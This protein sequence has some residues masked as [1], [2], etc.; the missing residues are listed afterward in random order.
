MEIQP[1]NMRCIPC[2]ITYLHV[3]IDK[4]HMKQCIENCTEWQH[5][6]RSSDIRVCSRNRSRHREWNYDWQNHGMQRRAAL[7]LS[8]RKREREN[9]ISF[10]LFA[11]HKM[12]ACVW[13]IQQ[14]ISHLSK[15]WKSQERNTNNDDRYVSACI[16]VVLSHLLVR[17]VADI[18]GMLP[19]SKWNPVWFHEKKSAFRQN[20][21]KINFYGFF[22]FQNEIVVEM[23]VFQNSQPYRYGSQN[24]AIFAC[25]N[26]C[27]TDCIMY[28]SMTN[29]CTIHR[30][31]E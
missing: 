2:K 18:G 27:S 5:S 13:L 12:F 30:P 25:V 10:H 28:D 29:V 9:H 26:E 14:N 17:L 20:L 8:H 24:S 1:T 31:Y 7:I 6:N 19:R 22:R 3:Y 23:Q 21:R 11:H 16:C 4:S 15:H